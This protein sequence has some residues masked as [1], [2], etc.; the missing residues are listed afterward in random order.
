MTDERLAEIERRASEATPGPWVTEQSIT[1]EQSV[2]WSVR[3]RD[4]LPEHPWT[5]RFVLWM[6]GLVLNLIPR[7]ASDSKW[8]PSCE[9]MVYGSREVHV[10]MRHDEQIEADAAFVAH[11]REDI[12]DLIQHIRLL[13]ARIKKHENGR[14]DANH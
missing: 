3:T 6:T 11:A 2:H 10:D 5:P 9:R 13:E 7:T 1:H 8:C 14:G 12:P 4:K